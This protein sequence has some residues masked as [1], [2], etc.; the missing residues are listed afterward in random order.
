MDEEVIQ[1]ETPTEEDSQVIEPSD[2]VFSIKTTPFTTVYD[3][4]LSKITDDMYVELTPED[5][6]RDLQSLLLEAIPGFE[7]P[8]C[9][10]T[11]YTISSEIKKR[12]EVTENDFVIGVIWHDL[13][14]EFDEFG[15]LITPSAE[16]EE[17][18]VEKSCFNCLVTSEEINILA[19]LMMTA[20]V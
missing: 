12:S 16:D 4:F 8:R 5:T 20:W 14:E 3:R 15:N 2:D 19:I 17:V 13:T 9:L 11:D 6:I 18:R 1:E 7:F 10:I